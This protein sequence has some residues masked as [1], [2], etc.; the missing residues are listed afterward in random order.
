MYDTAY[1][2]HTRSTYVIQL[3]QFISSPQCFAGEKDQE[4]L[5]KHEEYENMDAWIKSSSI[6]TGI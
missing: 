6:P 2:S 4:Y 3:N 1:R 5:K